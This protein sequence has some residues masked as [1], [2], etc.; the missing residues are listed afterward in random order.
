MLRASALGG[1]VF[2][3]Q[4]RCAAVKIRAAL[5]NQLVFA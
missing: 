4:Y 5:V 2:C 1:T 3:E